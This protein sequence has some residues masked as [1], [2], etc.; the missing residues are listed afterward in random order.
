MTDVPGHL[1]K[2][3]T[4]RHAIPLSLICLPVHFC[5]PTVYQ[6]CHQS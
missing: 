5:L 4:K 6:K 2:V 1:T 3:I